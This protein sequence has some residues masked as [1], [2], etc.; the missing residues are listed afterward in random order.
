MAGAQFTRLGTYNMVLPPEGP[1]VYQFKLDFTVQ[2]SQELDFTTEIQKEQISFIQSVAID[3]SLNN[4][5]LFFGAS[6]I[7]FQWLVPPLTRL[8]TMIPVTDVAKL[9]FST[10]PAANLSVPVL[11]MNTPVYPFIDA[12]SAGGGG[13][14]PNPLPVSQSGIWSVNQGGIWTVQQGGAP[15]AVGAA[16]TG[17]WVVGQAGA[18]WSVTAAQS[19]AWNVTAAQGG[20]PWSV[21]AAQ[22]GAWNVGQSGAWNFTP[23]SVP[24]GGGYTNRSI[25]LSGASQALMAANANRKILVVVNESTVNPAAINLIGGAA[26]LNTAGNVTLSPGGSLTLDT[27]PPTSA[28]TCIGTAGQPLTAFEG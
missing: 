11:V 16:Q 23:L 6:G 21:T 25:A 22:S 3:N 13:G 17:P 8:T 7:T 19:G 4:N 1:K 20:A 2:N 24:I 5:P 9:L 26:A 12:A 14:V 10:I 15:W 27:Y 18:P 28:L